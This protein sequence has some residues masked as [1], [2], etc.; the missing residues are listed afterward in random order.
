MNMDFEKC[1]CGAEPEILPTGIRCP[2]EECPDQLEI[3]GKIPL[4][5]W[6]LWNSIFSENEEEIVCDGCNVAEEFEHRCTGEQCQCEKCRGDQKD[7]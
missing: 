5:A 1:N 7:E 6:M 2:N 3:T 4:H